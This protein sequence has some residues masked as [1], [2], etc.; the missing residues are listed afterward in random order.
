MGAI[1]AASLKAAM[2]TQIDRVSGFFRCFEVTVRPYPATHHDSTTRP[3]PTTAPR[4]IGSSN[5]ITG[6]SARAKH[7][8]AARSRPNARRRRASCRKT[9]TREEVRGCGTRIASRQ[10]DSLADQHD[11]QSRSIGRCVRRAIG[12][13]GTGPTRVARFSKGDRIVPA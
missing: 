11:L 5:D 1:T 6:A 9:L 7:F 4:E 10:T 13:I 3:I 12:A 2:T 8:A